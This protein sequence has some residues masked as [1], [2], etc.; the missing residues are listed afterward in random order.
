MEIY[1]TNRKIGRSRMESTME[2]GSENTR[3][4]YMEHPIVDTDSPPIRKT[5]E[6]RIYSRLPTTN[7]GPRPKRIAR[8]HLRSKY[9]G[10]VEW[11][12]PSVL[13]NSSFSCIY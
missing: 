8:K 13:A 1:Y 10:G 6:G 3:R 5:N 2:G 7:G 4:S 11:S 12:L 9:Y